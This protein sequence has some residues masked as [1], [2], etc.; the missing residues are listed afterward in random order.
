VAHHEPPLRTPVPRSVCTSLICS[1]NLEGFDDVE[2]L[3]GDSR[4]AG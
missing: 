3:A 1:T 2:E 4:A